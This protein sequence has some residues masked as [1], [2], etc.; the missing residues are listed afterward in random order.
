MKIG[1]DGATF[2]GVALYTLHCSNDKP[3]TAKQGGLR[4]EPLVTLRK[5]RRVRNLSNKSSLAKTSAMFAVGTLLKMRHA[6]RWEI[7]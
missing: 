2:L 3:E 1:M 5:F 4:G 7:R 6:S